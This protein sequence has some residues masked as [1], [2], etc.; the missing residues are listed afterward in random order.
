MMQICDYHVIKNF[1]WIFEKKI[2][3]YGAGDAGHH[4]YD[5]IKS[6]GLAV[7]HVTQ[8][9]MN[10][11]VMVFEDGIL[12]QQISHIYNDINTENHLIIVSS[13]DYFD[14]M[15]EHL[16]ELGMGV[17]GGAYICTIYGFFMSLAINRTDKRIPTEYRELL[18][19][20][21]VIN[22]ARR[23]HK[24][25]QGCFPCFSGDIVSNS[26]AV[27]IYQPGKVGSST[28]RA[29]LN[30][31]NKTSI[32]V[33]W[34]NP[35][36]GCD[37]IW[38][39]HGM[40]FYT[41]IKN[42]PR[43]LITLVRNP[44]MRD[45][46]GLFQN[47]DVRYFW[48]PF[49]IG[50]AVSNVY[51]PGE[52]DILNLVND[53]D[54]ITVFG[55]LVPASNEYCDFCVKVMTQMGRMNYEFDWFDLQLKNYFDI[56]VYKYPFDKKNGYMIIK[57]GHLEVLVLRLENMKMLENVIGEFVEVKNFRLVN[58]NESRNKIYKYLYNYVKEN[59]VLPKEYF[60]CYMNNEKA[61]HFYTRE[62]LQGFL[63]EFK[64]E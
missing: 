59:I 34:L 28:I 61:L 22:L 58:A 39:T 11:A 56:D 46:S 37:E 3:L 1:G 43:K 12:V 17:A 5:A 50:N 18:K 32:H 44:F 49:I 23:R 19:A 16:K 36:P 55:K 45:F 51:F 7:S 8:T 52:D 41:W 35:P 4:A 25:A 9:T 21:Y 62:D 48:Y 63:E 13:Y 20:F 29:S 26:N 24:M 30:A 64:H 2:V 57:E 14:P 54:L 27:F 53:K 31:V 38:N 47:T 40:P 42:Q 10:K 60:D 15:I 33:H 6:L